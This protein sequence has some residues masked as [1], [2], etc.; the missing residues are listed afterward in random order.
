MLALTAAFAGR[1]KLLLL[2]D[3]FLFN[4]VDMDSD[5]GAFKGVHRSHRKTRTV[6]PRPGPLTA[7]ADEVHMTLSRPS[8]VTP[9]LSA[10]C[11]SCIPQES[12]NYFWTVLACLRRLFERRLTGKEGP[13][14]PAGEPDAKVTQCRNYGRWISSQRGRLNEVERYRIAALAKTGRRWPKA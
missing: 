10:R 1:T 14:P 11:P 5:R 7:A 12:R 8:R 2:P 6:S 9:S 4:R 3:V 13:P